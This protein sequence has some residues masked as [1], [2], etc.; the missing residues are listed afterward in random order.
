M[1][2]QRVVI[3]PSIISF[4]SS[5]RWVFALSFFSLFFFLFFLSLFF[6]LVSSLSYFFFFSFF[7]LQAMMVEMAKFGSL[8]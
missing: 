6:T 4:F 3:F 5:S 7:F 1:D 2:E 8:I